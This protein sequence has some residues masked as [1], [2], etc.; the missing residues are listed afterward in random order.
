[1]NVNVCFSV[2]IQ[3]S[4]DHVSSPEAS[5]APNQRLRY[6]RESEANKSTNGSGRVGTSSRVGEDRRQV[7]NSSH[8]AKEQQKTAVSSNRFDRLLYASTDRVLYPPRRK[9]RPP[10]KTAKGPGRPPK[11]KVNESEKPVKFDSKE[12]DKQGKAKKGQRTSKEKEIAQLTNNTNSLSLGKT[13]AKMNNTSNK[14]SVHKKSKSKL[15]FEICERVSKRLELHGKY[16]QS[17]E[18]GK[19]TKTK[20]QKSRTVLGAKNLKNENGKVRYTALKKLMH[21]KHKHKKHKKCK[22]KILKPLSATNTMADPKLNLE[23]EKLVVDFV[24]LCNISMAKS[25]SKEN[26]PEVIKH[27]KKTKKRKTSEYNERKKKKQN[28]TGTQSKDPSSNSE[29]RLPLKKRHYHLS[30]NENKL[31]T[32]DD[33][34]PK[35]PV[36]TKLDNKGR[37]SV[38]NGKALVKTAPISPKTTN[39][40]KSASPKI[41]TINN[42]NEYEVALVKTENSEEGA[43]KEEHIEAAIEACISR[44]STQSKTVV[45]QLIVSV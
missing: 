31:E 1:M 7:Q 44:Y 40:V 36:E 41:T 29:Q 24:K 28:A 42:N 23:I 27:L 16:T 22:F 10:L 25:A 4:P 18:N 14:D 30:T 2:G 37:N 33:K 32:S 3:N 20:T 15:L 38:A 21:S 12:K 13:D 17:T 8:K 34:R 45:S 6:G 35:T 11:H 19:S 5:P 9:G 39:A 43:T 26:V